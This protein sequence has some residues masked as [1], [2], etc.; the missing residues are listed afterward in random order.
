[1]VR[2]RRYR[3]ALSLKGQDALGRSGAPGGRDLSSFP[4][5]EDK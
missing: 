1:M 5:A 2:T 4:T 3:R